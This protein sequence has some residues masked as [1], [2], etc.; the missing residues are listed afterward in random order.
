MISFSFATSRESTSADELIGRLLHLIGMA[1]AVVLADGAVLLEL[2][3]Q[4]E[5]VSANVADGDLGLLGIFVR[6]LDHFL[7][8]L[9]VHLGNAQAD[10]LSLGLRVEAEI[11]FADRLFDRRHHAAIP[12]LHAQQAGLRHA[13][14]RNLR[15]RHRSAVGVHL[16]RIEQGWR[17]ASGAQAAEVVLEGIDGALSCG[18]SRLRG[19]KRWPS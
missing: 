11:G 13:H 1:L 14:G 5:P 6:D 9:L 8:A 4:V 12:D 19:Q 7:A 3:Q 2:L 15:D 16:D 10:D 18:A 17:G